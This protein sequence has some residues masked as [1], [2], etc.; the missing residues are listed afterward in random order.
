MCYGH[1]G[2]LKYP[3]ERDFYNEREINTMET[4]TQPTFSVEIASVAAQ[5]NLGSLQTIHQLSGSAML[6]IVLA[7]VIGNAIALALMVLGFSGLLTFGA[8]AGALG[9]VVLLESTLFLLTPVLSLIYLAQFL[10]FRPGAIYV[11]ER[12]LLSAKKQ[13]EA[14][15]WE[16]IQELQQRKSLL[17]TTTGAF[18]IPA[19]A[20]LIAYLVGLLG[21]LFLLVACALVWPLGA[22]IGRNYLLRRDDGHTYDINRSLN[23]SQAL[24]EKI[25]QETA[26]LLL[27]KAIETY[28][29][30]HFVHFGQFVSVN[31]DG[32]EYY[33]D[34]IPWQQIQH[35]EFNEKDSTLIITKNSG[36]VPLRWK[37]G[38][39]PNV[40]IAIALANH[41][42]SSQSTSS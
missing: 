2:N 37:L 6:N 8:S 3:N 22:L 16:R 36:G 33:T 11:F 25:Q 14:I 29:T 41:I 31:Q 40:S 32:L 17:N 9:I 19:A 35:L 20:V 18:A 1:Q 39:T 28:N 5:H 15:P 7:F 10:L 26:S 21:A 30:Q 13:P 27:A 23:N 42:L 38:L 24:L 12:G 4:K 34:R